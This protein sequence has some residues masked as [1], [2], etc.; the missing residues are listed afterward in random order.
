MGYQSIHTGNDIDTGITNIQQIFDLIYP[1]GSYYMSSSATNPETLFGGTWVQIKDTFLL[2]AGDI[3]TV[4]SV[5]G[6]SSINYTPK[7]TNTGTA[8]TAAQ[9]PKHRHTTRLWNYAG[10]QGKAKTTSNYGADVADCSYGL[11]K[12]TWGTWQNSS[13]T[14][15]QDGYGD[16]NGITDIAGNGATHTHT[17]NGTASVIPTMPPYK[18]VYAWERTA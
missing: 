5:G 13:F 14:C 4:G 15:A 1:V 9:M 3:Y 18:V 16:Q 17:F 7:G 8:I 10:T 6:A 11:G 12:A 2:T